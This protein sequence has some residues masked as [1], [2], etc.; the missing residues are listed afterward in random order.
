M[1]IIGLGH[2]SRTG[3]DT[4]ANACIEWLHNHTK[5][6][7]KKVPFAMK[8]KDVC[9]QLY[10]WA[11]LKDMAFYDS[12]EGEKYRDVVLPAL[13]VTPVE[14]W[15]KFGTPAVREQVYDGT[16]IDYVV[17]SDHDCDV[18]F[19]PDVRFPNEV[20]AVRDAGGVLNKV[21]R[22]GF[23][24]RQSVADLALMGFTGWDYI[25]GAHGDIDLLRVEAYKMG[26]AIAGM[27]DWPVQTHEEKLAA[28]AVEKLP[29]PKPEPTTAEAVREFGVTFTE[30]L[31]RAFLE[32]DAVAEREG[33][34]PT[35]CEGAAALD[36]LMVLI[37]ENHP[38]LAVEFRHLFA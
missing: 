16:W 2:Y 4:F 30:T 21:V 28:L 36:D 10:A 7:C 34:G 24:P 22:P 11:G 12:P 27:A 9:H 20:K 13:G 29:P 18:L 15:I 37:K 3:K 19:I 1:K 14:L 17:K 25:W 6:R 32:L 38:E 33:L 35:T 31:A 26:A 5:L 23:G 8:L